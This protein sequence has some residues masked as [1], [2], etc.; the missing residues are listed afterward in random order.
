MSGTLMMIAMVESW[1]AIRLCVSNDGD[2]RRSACGRMIIRMVCALVIP[3]A[4]AAFFCPAE[5]DWMPERM[6]SVKY[7]TSNAAN[8]A[9]AEKYAEFARPVIRG[10]TV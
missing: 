6:I 5:T 10:P 9:S 3:Q 8:A 4:R 1:N 2:M 7:A